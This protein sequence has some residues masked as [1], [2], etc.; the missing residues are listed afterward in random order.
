MNWPTARHILVRLPV[1]LGFIALIL[2]ASKHQV[3][4]SSGFISPA[5]G[6]LPSKEID[7]YL[8]MNSLLIGLCTGLL[9]ATG[10]VL[11]SG[12]KSSHWSGAKWFAVGSAVCVAL[13]IICG[14][15]AY[16]AIIAMLSEGVWDPYAPQLAWGR[17]AQF[18]AFL[19][20]V[21]L[22]GDFAFQ[23]FHVEDKHE[24]K[25]ASIGR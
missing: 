24:P 9:G 10:F 22:F 16:L 4:L 19:L 11:T 1:Y 2:V 20:A 7:I 23:T 21:L 17:D 13:S 8:Q 5:V 15:T 3:Q 12:R 25:P 14:Y 18:F 6:S